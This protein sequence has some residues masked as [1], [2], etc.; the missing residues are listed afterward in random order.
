MMAVKKRSRICRARIVFPRKKNLQNK[1]ANAVPIPALG[2]DD[3][4]D[5]LIAMRVVV[6]NCWMWKFRA[7]FAIANRE[8]LGMQDFS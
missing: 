3:E 6:A 8:W 1:Y 4:K 7:G 2:S 5:G